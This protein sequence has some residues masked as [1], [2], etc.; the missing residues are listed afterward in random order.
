MMLTRCPACQTAFR[1]G[2]E[3]LHARRGE[4]R[5]GHCF[6]PFNALEHEIVQRG[7]SRSLPAAPAHPPPPATAPTVTHQRTPA[8]QAE[9]AAEALAPTLDF[10][11]LEEKPLPT[12][13]D[14]AELSA[15]A[16]RVTEPPATTT[17]TTA[18]AAGTPPWR[19]RVVPDLDFDIPD[20]LPPTPPRASGTS[21][22]DTPPATEVRA[23]A[24]PEVM[25][26]SRRPAADVARMEPGAHAASSASYTAV[27]EQAHDAA[28]APWAA[29]SLSS[30]PQAM[31][32]SAQTRSGPVSTPDTPAHA[33]PDAE[34]EPDSHADAAA[35]VEIE[36]AHGTRTDI[37]P[38]YIAVEHLD[39]KYG[40]LR[41]PASP[42]LR[43]LSALAT[44]ALGGLLAAQCIYL[45][46][47]E[48]ARELPGLRPLMTQLCARLGCEIPFPRDADLIALDASDLQSEPGK[49]GQYIL[50]ATVN[51]RAEYAQ[52]WPHMELTL[53]DA[54]DQPIA[55]RVLAPEEWLP[56]DQHGTAQGV[57]S[58]ASHKAV[59]ARI[60]FAAADLSPTGYRV[61]IFYP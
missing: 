7:Q 8:V 54:G 23:P 56:E 53:T 60:A 20:D 39:A 31:T 51:N 46:R 36:S 21:S 47:M 50:H 10:I 24:M 26:S 37:K 2:P 30:A 17:S 55:R 12:P 34:P 40:R 45:Y 27:A 48:I 1:L 59:S 28:Y 38:A 52:T 9:R 19:S 3:Q 33:L 16:A 58:F 43:T 6:H 18:P 49:P 14:A 5:C 35:A 42:L 4:V 25:R 57:S 22:I 11:I 15:P 44:A 29:A 13:A 61:Y 32:K 41:K